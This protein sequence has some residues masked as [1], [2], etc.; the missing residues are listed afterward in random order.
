MDKNQLT[1][2][3]K[4]S[5]ERVL[6]FFP[7]VDAVSSVVLGVDIG[8]LALLANSILP[9]K[10]LEWRSLAFVAVAVVLIGSS[11]INL[12]RGSFPKLTGGWRSLL[13]FREIA[14]RDEAEFIR[15]FLAQNEDDYLND[16]LSQI[17]RNSEILTLKFNHLRLAFIFLAWAVV[18]WAIALALLASQTAETTKQVVN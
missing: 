4:N 11:L 14:Q 13:Y 15:E 12:Y 18:P 17:W 6:S 7:R 1:E 9:L 5:L 3:A 10:T 8:M 16:L 2:A